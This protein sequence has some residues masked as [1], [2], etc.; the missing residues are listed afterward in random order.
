MVYFF[1]SAY[2]QD[3][4]GYIVISTV[5]ASLVTPVIYIS[6]EP[7][8]FMRHST[9]LRLVDSNKTAFPL[10]SFV[11]LLKAD[12]GSTSEFYKV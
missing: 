5:L 1:R 4:P 2:G 11:F 7:F 12:T 6:G 3:H 9:Y 10:Y 8:S